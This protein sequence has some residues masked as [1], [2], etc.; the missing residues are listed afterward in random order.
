MERTLAILKPDVATKHED[1]IIHDIEKNGFTIYSR[2]RIRLTREQAQDFYAEHNGKPFF[3]GL[4]DFMTSG[5]IVVLALGKKDA[6]TAWRQ[7]LGPTDSAK[8]RAESKESIRARFGTDNRRNACHGSD[9]SKSAEREI[10]FFFAN[11]SPLALPSPDTIR[12]N[13]E[14]SVYPILTKGLTELCKQKPGNA[15]EWLGQWLIDNN[16]AKPKIEEPQEEVEET[17]HKSTKVAVAN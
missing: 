6:V 11:I 15:V 5:P 9:S 12:A 10:R 8:A 14:A 7:L 3:D 1:E 17:V 16:P 4:V 13:L 2:K